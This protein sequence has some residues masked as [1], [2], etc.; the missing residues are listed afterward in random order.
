LSSEELKLPETRA[1]ALTVTGPH[2]LV[3]RLILCTRG[4]K[5]HG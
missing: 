3:L 2:K 5:S 1:P 4:S